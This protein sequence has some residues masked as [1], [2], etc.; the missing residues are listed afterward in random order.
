VLIICRLRRDDDAETFTALARRCAQIVEQIG[1]RRL[2]EFV[3]NPERRREPIRALSRWGELRTCVSDRGH[4]DSI[5]YSAAGH[6]LTSYEPF[7]EAANTRQS[8]KDS[9]RS[10]CSGDAFVRIAA[11]RRG[12]E[13]SRLIE[14]FTRSTADEPRAGPAPS[15]GP[16]YRPT[17][18]LASDSP[19]A[20]AK[21]LP[22]AMTGTPSER[23]P[24]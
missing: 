22:G 5:A 1:I 17:T 15:E 7:R 19:A 18:E 16:K 9:S 23:P 6:G 12:E 10:N 2:R 24:T 13:A 20:P 21:S 4:D 8:A 14:D 3:V 11:A